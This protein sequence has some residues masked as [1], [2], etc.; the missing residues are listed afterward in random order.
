VASAETM[1]SAAIELAASLA[2]KDPETLAVL[3]QR[4]WGAVVGAMV[5]EASAG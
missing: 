1:R 3:K 4:M 5:T 2:G